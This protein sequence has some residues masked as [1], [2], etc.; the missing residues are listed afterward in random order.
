MKPFALTTD[1]EP[2]A[3]H[4]RVVAISATGGGH[5]MSIFDDDARGDAGGDPVLA[6]E[7]VPW[8]YVSVRDAASPRCRDDIDD[9]LGPYPEHSVAS[10]RDLGLSDCEIARY[11]GV[12]LDCIRRLSDSAKKA[13]W[14]RNL[15]QF[16]QTMRAKLFGGFFG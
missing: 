1:N 16:A 7:S 13:R 4:A 9:A 10:F 2:D 3:G 14:P 5:A 12:T 11:F 6:P 15:R 8:R